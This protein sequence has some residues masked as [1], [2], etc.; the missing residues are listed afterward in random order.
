MTSFVSVPFPLMMAQRMAPR[1]LKRS[2]SIMDELAVRGSVN[3]TLEK[4][5]SVERFFIERGL[6]FPAGGSLLV[7]ARKNGVHTATPPRQRLASASA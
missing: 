1:R 6:S 4:V 3:T 5:L 2:Q 7:I